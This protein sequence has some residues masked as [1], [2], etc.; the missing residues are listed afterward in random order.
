MI[1]SA[2]NAD[3]NAR[4]CSRPSL[5]ITQG[6]FDGCLHEQ[7]LKIHRNNLIAC[8]LLM[9]ISR[10]DTRMCPCAGLV[11]FGCV[12]GTPSPLLNDV[13]YFI[14]HYKDTFMALDLT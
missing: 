14:V 3:L 5:P 10:V 7:A 1:Q 12:Y 2:V 9:H 8:I 4:W 6:L 11:L 13:M